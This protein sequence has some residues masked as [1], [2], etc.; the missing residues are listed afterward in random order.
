MVIGRSAS[1]K[2]NDIDFLKRLFGVKDGGGGRVEG[3]GKK[4]G[5]KKDTIGVG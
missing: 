2:E 4:V 5:S 3:R 1:S